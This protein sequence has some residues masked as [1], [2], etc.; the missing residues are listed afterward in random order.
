MCL[1]CVF[2]SAAYG[3]LRSMTFSRASGTFIAVAIINSAPTE[4]SFWPGRV[5]S[6]HSGSEPRHVPSYSA[7]TEPSFCL[8]TATP[9][10]QRP[11]DTAHLSSVVFAQFKESH[12]VRV[13]HSGGLK[14]N[15]VMCVTAWC[16]CCG[17][18]RQAKSN[19]SKWKMQQQKKN[20]IHW[21]NAS[22]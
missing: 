4:T 16:S 1:L 17:A 2:R 15:F 12:I 20:T 10:P 5:N 6:C 18:L 3:R 14:S 19:L 11:A 22:C 8:T 7:A 13:Y 9:T 21:F